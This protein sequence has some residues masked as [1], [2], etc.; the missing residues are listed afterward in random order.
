MPEKNI[1][2]GKKS[3]ATKRIPT[4][5]TPSLYESLPEVGSDPVVRQPRNE[6]AFYRGLFIAVIA[7]VL[8]GFVI[9]LQSGQVRSSSSRYNAVLLNNGQVYFG[10]IQREDE[11]NLVLTNVFYIQYTEQQVPTTTEGEAPQ[12]VQTPQLVKKGSEFYGP[13]NAIRLNRQQIV[14]VEQ[15]RGDSQVMVQIKKMLAGN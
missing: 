7:V 8:I 4:P 1:P 3:S 6:S 10:Q 15:L 12:T 2:N 11:N 9:T 14:S 5:S 13:E